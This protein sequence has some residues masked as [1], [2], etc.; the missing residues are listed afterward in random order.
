ME[1]SGLNS[2]LIEPKIWSDVISLKYPCMK[3]LN[4][5]KQPAR[6]YVVSILSLKKKGPLVSS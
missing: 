2:A 5:K 1:V 6:K 4:V 3:T